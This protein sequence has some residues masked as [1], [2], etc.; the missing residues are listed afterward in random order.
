M[1]GQQAVQSTCGSELKFLKVPCESAGTSWEYIQSYQTESFQKETGS[2]MNP[3]FHHHLLNPIISRRVSFLNSHFCACFITSNLH[4]Q[5]KER[6][7]TGV[8]K[9][10]MHTT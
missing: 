8:Q 4:N 3:S 6:V 1:V 7:R 2:N 9:H 5:Y 10:I